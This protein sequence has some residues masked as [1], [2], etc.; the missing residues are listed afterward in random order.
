VIAAQLK[1]QYGRGTGAEAVQ[2]MT[3]HDALTSTSRETL[4]LLLGS[5]GL[6]LLIACANVAAA[7]LATGEERRS[8]LALARALGASRWRVVRQL[9]AESLTIGTAGA[10][11]GILLAGWASG[12]CCRSKPSDCREALK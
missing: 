3:L 9:L 5:V 11:L 6:V 1:E 7:M 8:E 12:R 10:A 2:V 4:W